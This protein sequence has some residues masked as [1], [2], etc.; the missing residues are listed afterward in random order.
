M[1]FNGRISIPSEVILGNRTQQYPTC[2]DEFITDWECP[3]SYE[4]IVLEYCL[5]RSGSVESLLEVRIDWHHSRKR[6]VSVRK[7]AGA[8]DAGAELKC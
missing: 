5:T 2:I 4:D 7:S 3:V 8:Q 6:L 1:S